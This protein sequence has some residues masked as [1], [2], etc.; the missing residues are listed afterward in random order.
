MRT[1]FFSICLLLSCAQLLQA[2]AYDKAY[3]GAKWLSAPS[4][5]RKKVRGKV[6]E[7]KSTLSPWDV[8]YVRELGHLYYLEEKDFARIISV[9]PSRTG[10]TVET[11]YYFYRQK[12]AMVKVLHKTEHASFQGLLESLVADYGKPRKESSKRNDETFVQHTFNLPKLIMEV[13][14]H[15]Y[16]VKGGYACKKLV[17]RIVH[18]D[19]IKAVK[20]Y[21][22]TLKAKYGKE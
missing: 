5:V 16:K 9:L 4:Q 20:A 21:H 7:D 2:G 19:Y 6:K 15:P 13:S 17:F 1:M 11:E 14:Y 10:G 18:R 8:P 3:F 22:D 12:L